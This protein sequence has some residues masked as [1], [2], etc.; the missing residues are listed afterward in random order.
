MGSG[1]KWADSH[2]EGR[3]PLTFTGSVG[4]HQLDPQD[5]AALRAATGFPVKAKWLNDTV[6]ASAYKHSFWIEGANAQYIDGARPRSRTP[7][8]SAPRSTSS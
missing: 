6:I 2:G 7:A 5:V 1:S 8:G 3:R 4:L